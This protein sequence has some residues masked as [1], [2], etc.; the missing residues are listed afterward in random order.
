MVHKVWCMISISPIQISNPKITWYQ[1]FL[2]FRCRCRCR[3]CFRSRPQN[4]RLPTSLFINKTTLYLSFSIHPVI[5][6]DSFNTRDIICRRDRP[7]YNGS[8]QCPRAEAS[9]RGGIK[10]CQ[11]HFSGA[12]KYYFTLDLPHV[13][14]PLHNHANLH[15]LLH[16]WLDEPGGL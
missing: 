3:Q 11:P 12:E 7:I 8:S 2:R 9:T 4:Y 16:C 10:F 6:S 1:R 14:H 15:S 5:Q 13:G